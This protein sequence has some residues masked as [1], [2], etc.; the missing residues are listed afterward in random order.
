MK[1]DYNCSGFK[2][3][4]KDYYFFS[5]GILQKILKMSMTA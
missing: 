2:G 5:L 4:T 3:E 1:K